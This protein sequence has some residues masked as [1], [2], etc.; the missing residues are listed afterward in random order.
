MELYS[1]FQNY[2]SAD[3]LQQGKMALEIKEIIENCAK[4]YQRFLTESEFEDLCWDVLINVIQCLTNNKFQFEFD[5]NVQSFKKDELPIYEKKY[6]NSFINKSNENEVLYLRMLQ[7]DNYSNEFIEKYKSFTFSCRFIG[8]I[9]NILHKKY[10]NIINHKK[11]LVVP[12]T[13]VM[14]TKTS[15][16]E[17]QET[18]QIKLCYLTNDELIFIKSFIDDN[19]I[20]TQSEVAKKFKISQQTVS[21]KL[22]KIYNKINGE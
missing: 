9:K 8:Y 17:F 18:L 4:T 7:N 14:I 20:L 12:L 10:A 21:L 19:K 6:L 13:D 22:I 3:D 16:V 1:I 11:Y 15:F 2:N 5:I